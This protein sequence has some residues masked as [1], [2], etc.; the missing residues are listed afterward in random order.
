MKEYIRII[1]LGGAC[2]IGANSYYVDWKG[3]FS[4]L[5]DC[6]LL[7]EGDYIES[8]PKF[9]LADS[10]VDAIVVSHAHN[11]HIGALLFGDKYLLKENG[12]IYMTEHTANLGMLII[13]DTGKI[14]R[15]KNKGVIDYSLEE[16]YKLEYLKELKKQKIKI[17]NYCEEY[18][19]FNDLKIKL[20]DAGHIF[21]SALIYIYDDETSLLYTGDFNLSD[22][23]LHNAA[24]IEDNLKVDILISEGTYGFKNENKI[25]LYEKKVNLAGFIKQTF[26]RKGNVL[27]PSFALGRAQEIL[28]AIREAQQDGL[29]DSNSIYISAGL[30]EKITEYYFAEYFDK[31]PEFDVLEYSELPRKNNFIYIATNGFFNMGS[32]ARN[33]YETIKDNDKNLVLFPSS[34][35]YNRNY[36]KEW[37]KNAKCR[38]ENIDFSAHAFKDEIV[39]IINKIDP[40]FTLFIH[41]EEKSLSDLKK[42]LGNEKQVFYPENNGDEIIFE[43][44]KGNIYCKL[45]NQEKSCI[46]TV[47]TS[48]FSEKNKNLTME[49]IT[50]AK[51]VSAELNTLFSI[52]NFQNEE[53]IYHLIC[54]EKSYEAGSRIKKFLESL[55][56][57][58]VLHKIKFDLV[59]DELE[60]KIEMSPIIS[61]ISRILLRYFES[62]IILT[63][64]FKFE[65]AFAYLLGNLF[66]VDMYYKHEDMKTLDSS[67]KIQN[68]PIKLDLPYFSDYMSK[69]EKLAFESEKTADEIYNSFPDEIK[70]LLY[71][72]KDRYFLT[73]LGCILYYSSKRIIKLVDSKMIFRDNSINE[74]IFSIQNNDE[75]VSTLD[76]KNP[77]FRFFL[78]SLLES[79]DIEN[80]LFTEV[81]DLTQ[82]LEEQ[83]VIF[84]PVTIKKNR[85]SA[86]LISKNKYQKIFIKFNCFDRKII[87]RFGLEE[88]KKLVF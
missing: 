48:I 6:G 58:V 25:S 81:F 38:V 1:P 2:E 51:Q 47:G 63:G 37:R 62:S 42:L 52:E 49:S 11:D 3:K 35:V 88:N 87:K 77:N 27:I 66:G 7:G 17:L 46:I 71:K 75:I 83:Q 86:N 60:G 5:L 82:A 73:N 61:G 28:A 15:K 32:P 34:Y 84:E 68:F 24:K 23:F 13:E 44:K 21:G 26:K 14:K 18:E 8:I 67:L 78:Y 22:S 56:Y 9:D 64:G 36:I 45:S 79:E 57:H 19:L 41:G 43:I 33:Y 12:K 76:I 4:F 30:C 29:I 20:F 72:K 53:Y 50:D 85:I 74:E 16:M 10:E 31:F 54:T 39:K 59:E 70:V 69:I 65:T 40:N 80:I 55:D